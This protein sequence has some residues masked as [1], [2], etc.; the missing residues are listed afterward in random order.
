MW[1]IYCDF[2]DK[3]KIEGI[4]RK[5]MKKTSHERERDTENLTSSV[6]LILWQKMG[7]LKKKEDIEKSQYKK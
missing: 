4:K 1:K 5:K 6:I 3:G 2:S 7:A